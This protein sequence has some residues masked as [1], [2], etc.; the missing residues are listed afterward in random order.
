MRYTI[1]IDTDNAAFQRR[2]GTEIARI[3]R[4]LVDR[5]EQSPGVPIGSLCDVNGNIVGSAIYGPVLPD[6]ST[7]PRF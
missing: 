5:C 3:L 4:G 6:G 1:T 2:C 7:G